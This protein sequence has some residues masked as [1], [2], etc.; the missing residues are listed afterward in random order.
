MRLRMFSKK[1]QELKNIL[2]FLIPTIT[3]LFLVISMIVLINSMRLLNDNDIE[4]DCLLNSEKNISECLK[5]DTKKIL[6]PNLIDKEY[7]SLKDLFEGSEN[8]RILISSRE[9]SDDIEKNHIIS[10]T[11]LEGETI[12]QGSI[13][14][15][16]LSLGKKLSTLPNIEGLTLS[17]ASI[18]LSNESFIPEKMDY[19]SDTVDYGLVIGYKDYDVGKSLET[20][21]RIKIIVSKGKEAKS[22]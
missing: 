13:V 17:E 9:Y 22:S 4:K 7:N 8:F 18:K 16:V 19:N 3:V 6:V 2:Y 10:Q 15:V 21:S 12:E 20:G 14:S 1:N 11:P 5:S